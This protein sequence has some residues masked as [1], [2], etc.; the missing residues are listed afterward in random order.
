[1]HPLQN[2]RAFYQSLYFKAVLQLVVI[3]AMVAAVPAIMSTGSAA[4]IA[5]RGVQERALAVTAMVAAE[6]SH[7]AEHGQ[8][9]ALDTLFE[10]TMQL[11]PSALIGAL[12]IA[13]DGTALTSRGTVPAALLSLAQTAASSRTPATSADGLLVAYPAEFGANQDPGAIALACPP[14]RPLPGCSAINGR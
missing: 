14:A 13:P 6:T 3:A 8:I 7:S 2:R 10:T 12:A 9:P 4:R 5:Q 1:M 11:S